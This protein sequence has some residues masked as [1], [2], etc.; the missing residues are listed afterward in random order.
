VSAQIGRS[1]SQSGPKP[2]RQTLAGALVSLANGQLRIE[3]AP[4]RRHRQ[5]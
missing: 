4:Q 1:R 5:L 3:V 2:L